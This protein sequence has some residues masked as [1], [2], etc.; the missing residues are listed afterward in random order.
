MTGGLPFLGAPRMYNL[1]LRWGNPNLLES[2]TCSVARRLTSSIEHLDW[3]SSHM[4]LTG[5]LTPPSKSHD[6]E[7]PSCN[8]FWCSAASWWWTWNALLSWLSYVFIPLFQKRGQLNQCQLSMVTAFMETSICASCP[9]VVGHSP[10]QKLLE[11]DWKCTSRHPSQHLHEH[12]CFPHAFPL[13]LSGQ[14]IDD[15][16]KEIKSLTIERNYY[17]VT[18]L[19]TTHWHTHMLRL[20]T[21]RLA[22][23]AG[24]V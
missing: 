13:R 16:W 14:G 21:I 24:S 1:R 7:T 17:K 8:W 6:I 15:W 11:A 5:N 10:R 22:R 3:R 20:V 19:T 4:I 12:H 2:T 18:S 23:E 9:W